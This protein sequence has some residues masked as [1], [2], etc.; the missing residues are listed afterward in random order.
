MGE[1]ARWSLKVSRDTDVALR[2]LLAGAATARP[3]VNFIGVE[4]DG[5]YLKIARRK[6][7]IRCLANV[8]LVHGDMVYFLLNHIRD[9]SIAAYH[10]YFPD[11]WPKRRHAKRRMVRDVSVQQFAR[12]LIPGGRLVV[13]TDVPV[14]YTRIRRAVN[15]SGLFTLEDMRAWGLDEAPDGDIP[16]NFE[17]KYHQIGKRTFYAR[18]RAKVQA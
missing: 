10:I 8:R 5:S 4:M 13:K 6:I 12:T 1:L 18:W 2:T 9:G 15:D 7:E 14:N 16:T 17:R 11:P 3:D